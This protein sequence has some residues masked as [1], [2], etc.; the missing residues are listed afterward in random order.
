MTEND[1]PEPARAKYR[2]VCALFL[3]RRE[4][5]ELPLLFASRKNLFAEMNCLSILHIY[6]IWRCHLYSLYTKSVVFWNLWI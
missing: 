2:E 3:A 6:N 5:E 4:I 1:L